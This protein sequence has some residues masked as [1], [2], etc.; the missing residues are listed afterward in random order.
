[1]NGRNKREGER[2]GG[3]DR[4]AKNESQEPTQL[5]GLNHETDK[6]TER[7]NF[8]EKHLLTSALP[9]KSQCRCRCR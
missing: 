3:Q 5:S 9:K 6:S 8:L 4:E 2:E 1:M 7:Q